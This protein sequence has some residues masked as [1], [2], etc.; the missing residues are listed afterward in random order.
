[1][2]VNP[3]AEATYRAAR[4]F[5]DNCLLGGGSLLWPGRQAWSVENL[6]ALWSFVIGNPDETDRSFFDKLK[7]QLE[8]APEDVCRVA[9]DILAFYYLFPMTVSAETK[10]DRLREIAGWKHLLAGYDDSLLLAAYQEGGLA[11]PG[12]YYATGL[13]WHVAYLIKLGQ[14]TLENHPDLARTSV[15]EEVLR[16]AGDEVGQSTNVMRNAALHLLAPESFESISSENHKLRILE[17]FSKYDP[18]EGSLDSRLLQVREKLSREVGRTQLTFYDPDIEPRWRVEKKHDVV[19]P[20]PTRTRQVW[21]EKTHVRGRA[22]R[23]AGEY[24][25]GRALWSPQRDKREADIYRFMREV[26][27]GDVVLHLTDNEGFTG[28]SVAAAGVDTDFTGL[29]DTDWAGDPGYLIRLRD[30]RPLD[31]PLHRDVFFSKPFVG[32]LKRIADE[33]TKNLFY[34]SEPSLNQGAYLTP[35]PPSV[36]AVLSAAYQ[37]IAERDL[38]EGTGP[39][40]PPAPPS[41]G[42]DEGLAAVCTAFSRALRECGVSFD[43][44]VVRSFVVSL[45]TKRFAILTGLSGSGK[46]QLALRFGEWLGARRCLV[47]PVRPDWTGAEALFGFEDALQMAEAGRRGWQVPEPLQFMLTAAADTAHPYLLLLDEMNLAHVERY[48]ADV[49]SGMESEKPCLPNLAVESDGVWRLKPGAEAKV[50]VP[51][52]LLVVGTVNVDETTYMFSPK[53]LDRANT[54][55]FRVRTEDLVAAAV[56]P[57]PCVAGPPSLVA[58][59]NSV[60]TDVDWHLRHSGAETERFAAY[61]RRLHELLQPIGFEFGHRTFVEAV[62]FASLLAAAGDA[63][64]EHALD[65]Q[66]MQKV[67]PRLHGSRRRLEPALSVLGSFCMDPNVPGT[68]EGAGVQPFDPLAM[69]PQ[70]AR[71]PIA[72]D[73]IRRMTA[74]VRANQFVSFTE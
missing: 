12:I 28:V 62:R 73:K 14:Y 68:L 2:A 56:R 70:P 39:A 5:R 42:S 23:Q 52:N 71:L 69:Q 19:P 49:L 3:D 11:N 4:L 31:P 59:F 26:Q 67:L 55:E 64:P 29:P 16:H 66:V 32:E 37:S 22:D 61:F 25:L 36:V 63:D 6:R 53:V 65:L 41:L 50:A 9:A 38:I 24:S 10:R 57:K 30:F 13:P 44:S 20:V 18:G 43:N 27:A 48:F 8:R 7:D 54:F 47:I 74:L 51:K 45:A 15:L 21:V 72:F 33:G 35:A 34:N 17:T 58:Q 46:T 40:E 60:A 1:M